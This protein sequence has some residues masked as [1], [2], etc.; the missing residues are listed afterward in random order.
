MM[1]VKIITTVQEFIDNLGTVVSSRVYQDIKSLREFGKNLGL[2]YARK[3]GDNMYELRTLGK[4]QVRLI[5]CFAGNVCYV[6]HGFLKKT[7]KIPV[8]ELRVAEKRIK[9]L[10]W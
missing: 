9:Q 5:Y 1:I 4:T 8:K 6:V 2:P 7:N 10:A 3:I